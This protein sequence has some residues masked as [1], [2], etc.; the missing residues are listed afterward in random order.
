[1]MLEAEILSY[2][3]HMCMLVLR[4]DMVATCCLVDVQCSFMVIVNWCKVQYVVL[5]LVLNIYM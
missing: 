5:V 2:Q 3:Y 4:Y 1:M